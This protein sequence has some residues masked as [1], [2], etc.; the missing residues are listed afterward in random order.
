MVLEL[1]D[2]SSVFTIVG[3]IILIV[4]MFQIVPLL[5]ELRL[6]IIECRQTLTSIR[7]LSN[8]SQQVVE[9]ADANL[10][11][12]NELKAKATSVGQMAMEHIATLLFNP[13]K[14]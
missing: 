10:E 2:L 13:S 4:L 6:T 12:F 14:E 11:E 8:T 1:R 7:E 5:K 3:I 9:K